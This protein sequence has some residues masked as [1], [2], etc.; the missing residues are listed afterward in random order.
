MHV[1]TC[2]SLV[3]LQIADTNYIPASAL[4]LC[5]YVFLCVC[6]C[7]CVIPTWPFAVKITFLRYAWRFSTLAFFLSHPPFRFPLCLDTV[8]LIYIHS[9][10]ESPGSPTVVQRVALT[11]TSDALCGGPILALSSFGSVCLLPF[12]G[13]TFS[14]RPSLSNSAFVLSLYYQLQWIRF[15]N[16][17]FLCGNRLIWS[18]KMTFS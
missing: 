18:S 10:A 6:V 14:L 16:K 1:C 13:H 5:V 2:I 15:A 4:Y 7:A 3:V 17:Y 12:L 8:S 11:E 9:Q